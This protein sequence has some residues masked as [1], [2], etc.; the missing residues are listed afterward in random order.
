MYH[1][2]LPHIIRHKHPCILLCVLVWSQIIRHLVSWMCHVFAIV[3]RTFT[4]FTTHCSMCL[5]CFLVCSHVLRHTVPC[6]C[7]IFSCAHMFFDKCF[8]YFAMFSRVFTFFLAQCFMYFAL[9]SRVV[10]C[11]WAQCFMYFA[12]FS[13]VFTG[14][15][16]FAKG[17]A[18]L[19]T[20][21][22]PQSPQESQYSKHRA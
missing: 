8:I 6:V 12:V 3:S 1:V 20:M 22:L 21:R 19:N 2:G 18:I 10:T 7:R 15:L 9:F 11:F 14:F 17:L 13:P 5:P 4:G 16:L